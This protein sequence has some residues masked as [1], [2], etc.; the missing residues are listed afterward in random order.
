MGMVRLEQWTD[1]VTEPDNVGVEAFELDAFS[2]S[3]NLY[4]V[5]G[6]DGLG[7]LVYLVKELEYLLLVRYC[8]IETFEFRL[9]T[10]DVAQVVNL[11]QLKVLVFGINPLLL[12]K[13]G[14]ISFRERMSLI[15]SRIWLSLYLMTILLCFI[16]R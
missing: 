6:T 1:R 15:M 8:H 3:D 7:G 2:V 16:G 10:Q 12:E 13:V 14:E 5:Y 11:L 9:L 4:Y